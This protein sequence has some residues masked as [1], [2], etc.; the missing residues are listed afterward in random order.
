MHGQFYRHAIHGL[1]LLVPLVACTGPAPTPATPSLECGTSESAEG[2]VVDPCT[3]ITSGVEGHGVGY[4]IAAGTLG[5]SRGVAVSGLCGNEVDNVVCDGGIYFLEGNLHKY[6]ENED[7]LGTTPTFWERDFTFSLGAR[8]DFVQAGVLASRGSAGTY[9]MQVV[10]GS[11]V[12]V[13]ADPDVEIVAAAEPPIGQRVVPCG[14]IT[15]NGYAD[16]CSGSGSL[17]VYPGPLD[18]AS[19]PIWTSPFVSLPLGELFN[20][21]DGRHVFAFLGG[22]G[23]GANGVRFVGLGDTELSPSVFA[24]QPGENTGREA[25][26]V[27]L[28][29]DVEDEIIVPSYQANGQLGQLRI[30][31]DLDPWNTEAPGVL[32]HQIESSGTEWFGQ[33][34]AVGDFDGDGVED[35]AVTALGGWTS[36]GRVHVFRG[37][38][39]AMGWDDVVT[40]RGPSAPFILDRFGF[41]LAVYDIDEDGMDDLVVGASWDSYSADFAGALY[42]ITDP[43][44][45]P[46]SE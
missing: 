9:L 25:I 23:E 11:P 24:T 28:D 21:D 35:L 22:E 1:T 6:T 38:I 13:N 14:D 39:D 20:L 10:P 32:V 19:S 3:R 7:G 26:P 45:P 29:D 44:D 41:D 16:L 36:S 27:Q 43:L 46:T 33:Q 12:D 31:D 8:F 17:A 15:G 40:W 37:P 2:F 42:L 18:A 30:Y 34:M 4:E 5:T